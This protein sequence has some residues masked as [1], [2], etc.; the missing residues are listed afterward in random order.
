MD[1]TASCLSHMCHCHSPGGHSPGGHLEVITTT[2]HKHKLFH[3]EVGQQGTI[4]SGSLI[5]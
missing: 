4:T 2:F 5:T 1:N 3:L